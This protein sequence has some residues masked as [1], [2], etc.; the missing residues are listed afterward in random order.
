[1]INL[2]S[3]WT[4][5]KHFAGKAWVTTNKVLSAADRYADIALRLADTG[6]FGSRAM[7]AGRDAMDRYAEARGQID[8]YRNQAV[9]MH[10]K[11][12]SAVP[13]IGL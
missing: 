1:M 7:Q 10:D 2:G 12:R 13:E 4:K 5:A 11:V 8:S 6:V 3:H 9:R